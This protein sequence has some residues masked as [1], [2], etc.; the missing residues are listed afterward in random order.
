LTD[1]LPPEITAATGLDALTQCLESYLSQKANPATDALA[2]EG[3]SRAARSLVPAFRGGDVSAARDDMALAALLSGICLTNA[4]LGAVHG[5]AAALGGQFP[6]PHGAACG[7]LLPH[8]LS[9]NIRALAVLSPSHPTLAK[10]RR[11]MEI[12]VPECEGLEGG[13][14]VLCVDRLLEL[15]TQMKIPR[16]SSYG[17][18]AADLPALAAAAAR[19][20]SIKG[21]PVVLPETALVDIL[22]AA[23]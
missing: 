16:L 6:V 4:G 10:F 14:T 20:G 2:L 3:L 21:N 19:T 7:L 8:V 18:D 23:L 22:R 9:A 1:S 11:V 15:T 5:L 17:I 12:L 13:K